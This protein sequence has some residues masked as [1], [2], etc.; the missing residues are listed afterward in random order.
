M[1]RTHLIVLPLLF[2]SLQIGAQNTNS[3]T[4]TNSQ[5]FSRPNELIVL[6]R[7][8]LEKKLGNIPT[9]IQV[10]VKGQNLIVQHDD[11]NG[12]GRWDEVALIYSFAP[13]EKT[14][15]TITPIKKEKVIH[16]VQRSHVRLRKKDAFNHWGANLKF[17]EMPLLNQ[18][19]DFSK[20]PLPLYLTEGPAWENDKVGFRLYFDVRNGKDIWGKTTSRMVMDSVGT[21]AAPSYHTYAAWGMDVLKVGKSLGAGALALLVPLDEQKDTLIRLGGN[22]IR[23]TAYRQICDGPVRA[24]FEMKY[25]WEVKGKP[26]QIIEQVSIWGGQYFYESKVWVTGAPDGV[27]L[28]TGIVN[29]KENSSQAFAVGR[30]TTL[31]S[32]GLQSEN[33]DRLGMAVLVPTNSFAFAG[34]SPKSGSDVLDTYLISQKISSTEPCRFRFFAAWEKSNPLFSSFNSFQTFI[35]EEAMKMSLPVKVHF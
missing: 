8:N 18:A 35:R 21:K 12:D 1:N 2:V 24:S 23:R 26:V 31:L 22:N 32:H 10:S 15:F 29:L 5:P 9:F 27:Q 34:T 11:V 25:D 3:L 20:H 4:V 30:I 17:E 14:H 19:T 7:T 28:V 16:D 33:N 13:S 6:K